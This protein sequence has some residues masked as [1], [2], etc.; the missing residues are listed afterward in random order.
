MLASCKEIPHVS[1]KAGRDVGHPATS[2][3]YN[4]GVLQRF[5]QETNVAVEPRLNLVLLQRRFAI[6][7]LRSSESIPPWVLNA[8]GFFALVRTSDELSVVCEE[9]VP[10]T[11][12]R[13]ESGWR[14]F[15]VEGPLEF[16][17]TG[18]LLA[19]VKPLSDAGV[20][21]FAISTFDTDYLLV[22]EEAVDAAEHALAEAGH[23]IKRQLLG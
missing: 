15:M 5:V 2:R 17:M 6:C 19:L 23:R 14:M 8:S 3:S 9:N 1:P 10:P 12:V 18:V 21:L 16:A 4:A 20:S 7:R 11:N 22:R 13:N